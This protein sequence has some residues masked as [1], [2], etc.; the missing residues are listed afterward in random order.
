MYKYI[1]TQELLNQDTLT[2][3]DILNIKKRLNGY[4]KSQDE[5]KSINDFKM[6]DEYALTLE[7]SNKGIAWLINHCF[8]P[9]SFD[10]LKEAWETSNHDTIDISK[11]MRK[12]SVFG[13]R[14]ALT[15]LD[16]AHFTFIG[17]Y[18]E[19]NL[20]QG[21]HNYLPLWKCYAKDGDSFEYYVKNGEAQIVG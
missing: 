15:I 9:S 1:P 5:G 3:R 4:A 13:Y 8:K 12:N 14:E 11:A 16:F 19:R 7:Q 18:D 2:E 10:E 6:K 20:Y 17:Y 21:F